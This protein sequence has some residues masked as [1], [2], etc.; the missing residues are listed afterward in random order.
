MQPVAAR[1]MVG[2]L[3]RVALR[4]GYRSDVRRLRMTAARS[5]RR[6]APDICTQRRARR[7]PEENPHHPPGDR[8]PYTTIS[9]TSA[10]KR[11]QRLDVDR[12]HRQLVEPLIGLLLLLERPLELRR[13]VG[14][15]EDLGV[16]AHRAVG[17]D[18]VVLDFLGGGD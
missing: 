2:V 7:Y 11:L 8:R 3:R 4:A 5:K 1:R 9:A 17:G 14:V 16:R 6:R 13:G 12:A 18:L 10:T 15:A